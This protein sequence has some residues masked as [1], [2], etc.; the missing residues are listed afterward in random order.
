MS[1]FVHLD[2]FM[3]QGDDSISIITAG[4]DEFLIRDKISKSNTTIIIKVA[5]HLKKIKKIA[6]DLGL[7]ETSMY[8]SQ[9]D[10]AHQYSDRLSMISDE[11]IEYFS[12][13]IIKNHKLN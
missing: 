2:D 11:V 10:Q 6:T 9:I 3:G 4:T 5:K 8:I 12:I 13:I 1:A 7:L